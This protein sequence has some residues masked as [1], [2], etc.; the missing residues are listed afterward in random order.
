[1]C[2][3]AKLVLIAGKPLSEIILL[4]VFFCLVAF[5]TKMP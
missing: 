1:M 2:L 4:E 3:D 5:M